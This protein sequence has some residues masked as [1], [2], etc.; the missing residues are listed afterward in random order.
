MSHTPAYNSS[1]CESVRVCE[2]L[3]KCVTVIMFYVAIKMKVKLGKYEVIFFKDLPS[4]ANIKLY[5]P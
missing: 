4:V 1:D 2:Q 5:I 3:N